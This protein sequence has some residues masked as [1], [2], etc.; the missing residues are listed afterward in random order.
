MHRG[1]ALMKKISI[2]IPYHRNKKMLLTSLKTLSESLNDAINLEIIVVANNVNQDEMQL[3]LDNSK[4]KVLCFSQNLFYPEAI[5]KGAQIASGDYLIF[6]DPDIF[7]TENWLEQMLNC[8]QTHTN[9]GCV[10][11]KLINPNDNRILDFG[12]GYHG[13]HTI[14]FFRGLPYDHELCSS[15]INVQSICS[16]LLLMEHSL[17]ES[18]KGFDTEMPYAYCDND[19]CL[20]IREKGYEIWGASNALAYHKGTTDSQ[21]SKYY[22]FKYLREDCTAAFFY[23]N[24]NRYYN[25]FYKYFLQSAKYFRLA[26]TKTAY[27][28]INL[29]TA[30][31]WKSYMQLIQAA[32]I[33]ILDTSEETV[34]ERN[35]HKL[36]FFNVIDMYLISS[37]TPLIYFV[38]SFTSCYENSLWFSLRDIHNDI[39][40]DRNAN[41]IPCWYIAN[42]LL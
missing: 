37:K 31:D 26:E 10:G 22:A 30:Y 35:I 18:L 20:R 2:I 24:I 13:Y 5:H 40:I 32:G 23:K 14:H 11:A 36:D 29:S 25:D 7:Y 19:L 41:C 42:N 9:V 1:N 39:I 3:D 38:D 6:A 34:P 15:D 17:F 16:A 12:I 21:N 28:F 4:Y 33:N 27:I 8:Y